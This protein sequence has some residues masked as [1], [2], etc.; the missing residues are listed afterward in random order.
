MKK[1]I[2][3]IKTLLI[4]SWKFNLFVLILLVLGVTCGAIYYNLLSKSDLDSVFSTMN[5][6]TN[7]IKN[8]SYNYVQAL[9]HSLGNNLFYIVIIFILGLSMIG[10][11]FIIMLIFLKGL[12][13]GFTVSTLIGLYK[14]KGS[15]YSFIYIFPKEILSFI[16]YI[17]IGYYSINFSILIF[18]QIFKKEKVSIRKELEKYL[19]VLG[20]TSFIGIIT[21]LL[22]AYLYPNLF[23]LLLNLLK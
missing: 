19:V 12:T 3:S 22:D 13:V 1:K 7:S 4:P 14:Y 10:I 21:S 9:L 2:S 5:D 16:S 23:N 18:K 6:F 20:I 8:N 15:L 11:P 17:I